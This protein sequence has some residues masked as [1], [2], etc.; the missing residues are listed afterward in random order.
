MLM[1]S[2]VKFQPT[3]QE[4]LLSAKLKVKSIKLNRKSEIPPNP[5]TSS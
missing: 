3:D 4:I 1:S 5:K 2:D